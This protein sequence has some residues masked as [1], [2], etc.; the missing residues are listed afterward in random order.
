MCGKR[1]LARAEVLD[2]G[3][4]QMAYEIDVLAVGEGERSG[5]A[6]AVRCGNLKGGPDEQSVIVIDGGTLDS[7]ERLVNLIKKTYRTRRVRMALSTH[8][9]GDHS[10]GLTVVLEELDVD[11]LW[12]H[13]PWDHSPEIRG[14]FADGT[15]SNDRLSNTLRK[16]LENASD[17]DKIAR[18]KGIPVFE[19]FSDNG[20]NGRYPG[21]VHVLGPT[22]AYYESLLPHFRDTPDAAATFSANEGFRSFY[23]RAAGVVTKVLENWGIETLKEPAEDAMSA[24]NNSSAILLLTID[25]RNLLFTAD[26][27]VPALTRAVNYAAT[28]GI[29]LRTCVFE[30]VP[31]HGSKRNVGPTILNR[32]VGPRLSGPTSSTKMTVVVSA[33]T[34]GEPKHP[35]AKVTNAYLRRGARVL[36]TQGSNVLIR[37]ETPPRPGYGP[38]EPVPFKPEVEEE[39]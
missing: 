31:H 37:H 20:I 25:G 34:E 24:E 16:E 15:L 17:L 8:P 4:S 32:I 38:A 14:W 1:R 33:A 3:T 5:D 27:G 13:K 36:A 29:D 11:E 7:G 26:A 10:S 18:R 39:D 6:I 2:G 28:V 22:K 19:P 21:V 12:M 35:A 9:D 30:M 23:E